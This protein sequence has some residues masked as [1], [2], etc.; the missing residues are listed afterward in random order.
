MINQ[1]RN[2]NSHFTLSYAEYTADSSWFNK[3]T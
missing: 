1:S 3:E 2:G